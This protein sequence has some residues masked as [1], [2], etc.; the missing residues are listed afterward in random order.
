MTDLPTLVLWAIT[1]TAALW[2][3][4]K[5]RIPN[6]LVGPGLVAGLI[7]AA[8]AGGL[9]GVGWSLLG[10]VVPFALLAPIWRLDPRLIRAGDIKLYMCIGAFLGW[11]GVLMVILYGHLF[12][13]VFALA[14][15]GW[16]EIE[17]RRASTDEAKAALVAPTQTP[18]ALPILAGTLFHTTLPH[19]LV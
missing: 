14:Q 19:L 1:C 12:K 8:H 5:W 10:A 15:L 7:F 18:A 16:F 4:T 13:G 2:D 3:L 9:P 11:K 6:M 17:K